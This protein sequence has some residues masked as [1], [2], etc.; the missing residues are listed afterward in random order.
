M[1]KVASLFSVA[2]MA[3]SLQSCEPIEP[4]EPPI[5]TGVD[6]TI[7]ISLSL[8][9]GCNSTAGYSSTTG[10]PCNSSSPGEGM[11]QVNNTAQTD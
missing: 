10:Q 4:C 8:P 1:K 6:T 2:I 9:A 3:F 5:Q 7:T 11:I